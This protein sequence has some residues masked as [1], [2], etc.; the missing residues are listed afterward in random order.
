MYIIL[1][2]QSVALHLFHRLKRLRPG[3]IV[4]FSEQVIIVDTS[5]TKYNDPL[6]NEL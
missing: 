3:R 2:F 5:F 4:H 6:N 1:W